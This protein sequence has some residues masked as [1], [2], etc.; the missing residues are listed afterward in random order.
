[1][2]IFNK[3][4]HLELMSA[5]DNYLLLYIFIY[6]PLLKKKKKVKIKQKIEDIDF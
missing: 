2:L 4:R 1:M 3:L 6:T 5:L